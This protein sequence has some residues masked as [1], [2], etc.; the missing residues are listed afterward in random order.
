MSDE[1]E[2]VRMT[3][4]EIAVMR[5]IIKWCKA[6]G[7]EET[8]AARW[9]AKKEISW[10][11]NA[12]RARAVDLDLRWHGLRVALGGELSHTWRDVPAR[13]FTEGVDMLVALGFLPAQ[14]SSAYRAGW[15]GRNSATDSDGCVDLVTWPEYAPAVPAAW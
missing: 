6:E 9:E 14:F 1:A 13:T 12:R 10:S 5:E 15:E 11:P 8:Y 3:V 4:D 2:W 7:V